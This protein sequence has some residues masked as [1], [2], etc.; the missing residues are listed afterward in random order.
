MITEEQ[1]KKIK[2]LAFECIQAAVIQATV[3]TEAEHRKCLVRTM[4]CKQNFEQ[5]LE[6]IQEVS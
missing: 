1:S 2:Q 6:S 5:Y 4:E 3:Q